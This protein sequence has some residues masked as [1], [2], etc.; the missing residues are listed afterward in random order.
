MI[1]NLIENLHCFP[2]SGVAIGIRKNQHEY[3]T[4]PFRSIKNLVIWKFRDSSK[5]IFTKNENLSITFDTMCY[6]GV[7]R[8]S[9]VVR[10][11]LN[12]FW[13]IINDDIGC[14]FFIEQGYNSIF[15]VGSSFEARLYV[16]ISLPGGLN[17]F[18]SALLLLHIRSM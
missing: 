3:H 18:F 10:L 2:N 15:I 12:N 14:F 9:L 1:L 13:K 6:S 8:K 17:F 4:R 11:S 7:P 5:L 16:V